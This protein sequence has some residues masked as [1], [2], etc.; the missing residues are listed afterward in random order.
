MAEFPALPLWTDA[1]LGD[2][3]HLTTIEHGAYLLLLMAMWRANGSLP[4]DDRMLA[5][6][7]KLTAGQWA[8]IAP[9][10]RPFFR[11]ENGR[12]SQGR[13]TDEL[14]HVRQHST[15]QSN[16]AKARWLK[17]NDTNDATAMPNEC[18]GNAPT[19]TPT[20]KGKEIGKP[21][22]SAHDGF[23]EFWQAVPRKIAK[24]K[25]QEAF[26]KALRKTDAGTIIAAM[27]RYAE[28]RMGEE[29][30]YTAHPA[31]WLDAGRWTDEPDPQKQ[32][33]ITGG[34]HGGTDSKLTTWADNIRTGRE[35]MCRSI[36]A[37]AARELVHRGMV[38]LDQCKRAG[39]SI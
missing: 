8:R 31:S 18:H 12:I 26:A 32:L 37:T 27:R 11:S 29:P 2:T 9:T 20:P 34:N 25:A 17:S 24:P 3:T 22:S 35:Y 6:Y 15:K 14:K 5:R 21:I 4:D 19:P 1:Y 28:A 36:P 13:L 10:V 39:V 30:K 7:T 33:Q 16:A 38:T 23:D